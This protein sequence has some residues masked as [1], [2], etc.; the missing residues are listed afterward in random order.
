M[1]TDDRAEITDDKKGKLTTYVDWS[2]YPS[3]IYID[4]DESHFHCGHI[5]PPQ[6]IS[7]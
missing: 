4:G 7:Y 6:K 2:S 5:R 3:F 1:N